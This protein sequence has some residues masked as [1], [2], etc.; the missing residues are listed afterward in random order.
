MLNKYFLIPYQVFKNL[1][2]FLEN[3]QPEDDLFD[4]L[5]VRNTQ[6]Y[7]KELFTFLVVLPVSPSYFLS[8]SCLS[9]CPSPA[10]FDSE[11]ALTGADGWP[12]S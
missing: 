4:R 5:N 10:D 3:K 8:P 1:Q 11:Q 9:Y 12:D 2:L 6:E 7:Q